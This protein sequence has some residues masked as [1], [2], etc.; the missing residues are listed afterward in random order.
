MCVVLQKAVTL[1]KVSDGGD[2]SVEIEEVGSR[3]LTQDM[4]HSEVRGARDCGSPGNLTTPTPLKHVCC[5]TRLAF[6]NIYFDPC[7]VSV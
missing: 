3:P 2:D 7:Y 4:L 6:Q 5:T 1:Y